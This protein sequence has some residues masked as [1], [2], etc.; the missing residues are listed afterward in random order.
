MEQKDDGID[1]LPAVS[2][3]VRGDH[4]QGIFLDQL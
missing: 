2:A 1:D 4:I 3:A